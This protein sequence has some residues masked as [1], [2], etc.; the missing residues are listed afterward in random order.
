MT[1]HKD[2]TKQ[3]PTPKALTRLSNYA[4]SYVEDTLDDLYTDFREYTPGASYRHAARMNSAE[5]QELLSVYRRL[6]SMGEA[7]F[8]WHTSGDFADSDGRPRSLPRTGRLSLTSLAMRVA[9]SR[10]KAAAIVG[11]LVDLNIL[12]EGKSTFL[13]GQRS[14]I[15]GT[16]NAVASAY[17]AVIISRLIRTLQHN[18]ARSRPARF[19][20]SV[21]EVNILESDLPSFHAFAR[22]QGEYF[23]DAVDD[24]LAQRARKNPRSS[25]TVAVGV[26]AF[27]WVEPS[28]RGQMA[29]SSTI[30]RC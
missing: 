18:F 14:A 29:R 2:K 11:D 4:R 1:V 13:P 10:A 3:Q 21:T 26:G 17:S 28:P 27:S 7:L 9:K 8:I 6:R 15:L 19:E 25:K 24:W 16:D 30:E 22:Q 12:R 5:L 20:R 23:I